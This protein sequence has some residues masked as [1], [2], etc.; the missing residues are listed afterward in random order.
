MHGEWTAEEILRRGAQIH[1]R[2]LEEKRKLPLLELTSI[3]E[4]KKSD[5]FEGSSHDQESGRVH[6]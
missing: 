2:K 1:R 3:K 4:E 6:K 5:W